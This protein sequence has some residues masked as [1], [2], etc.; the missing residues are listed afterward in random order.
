MARPP[1]RRLG[2]RRRSS[3]AEIPSKLDRNLPQLPVAMHP[4]FLAVQTDRGRVIC[5]NCDEKELLEKLF[6]TQAKRLRRLVTVLTTSASVTEIRKIT[7][8]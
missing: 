5:Y 3:V 6:R 8:K 7:Q 1:I 4:A 2:R